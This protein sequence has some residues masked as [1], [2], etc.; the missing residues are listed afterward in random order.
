VLSQQ[1]EARPG[2]LQGDTGN[3]NDTLLA[4]LQSSSAPALPYTAL[5][6]QQQQA[7]Q[8]GIL[9]HE[10]PGAVVYQ[11][12]PE[13]PEQVQV[14]ERPSARELSKFPFMYSDAAVGRMMN[15]QPFD[16]VRPHKS[17]S[18]TLYQA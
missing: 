7:A 11:Q 16:V 9:H 1:Q 2:W 5:H 17:R 15:G 12:Q 13:L 14:L 4:A 10:R 18:T 3:V 8:G 6:D